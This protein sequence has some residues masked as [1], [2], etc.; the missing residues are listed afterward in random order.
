MSQNILNTLELKEFEAEVHQVFQEQGTPFDSICRYRRTSG[1]SVQFP[2]LGKLKATTRVV[3]TP[4][5]TSNQTATAVTVT[6]GKF[7]VAQYTDIF[8]ASEVNFDAKREAAQSVAMALGR[9]QTQIGLDA[10]ALGTYTNLQVATNITGSADGLRFA[11]VT[12]ATK[13][14]DAAA[15]NMGGERI[16]LA[17]SNGWHRMVLKDQTSIANTFYVTEKPNMTGKVF[18]FY[19][20][21]WA[22]VG[23]NADENGM[24]KSTNTRSNYA[25]YKSALGMAVN[26]APEIHVDWVAHM[27][28]WLVSGFLDCGASI[29][30]NS[31]IIEVLTDESVTS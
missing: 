17:H 22:L 1:N 2:V 5:V 27:G 10:L 20:Y 31:G 4:L 29:I 12:A 26:M 13:I 24:K 6:L 3:G 11:S 7:T 18:D 21:K 28:S 25:Y 30:D 9:K 16:F 23:D 14:L 15:L 19:G 8:L